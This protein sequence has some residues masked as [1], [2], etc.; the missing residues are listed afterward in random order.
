MEERPMSAGKQRLRPVAKSLPQGIR[1]FL[2][3]SLFKQVRSVRSR[4]KLPRWDI[5][6]L[7][8]VLI[9]CSWCC[10][11]SLPERFEVARGFYVFT[12]PK[13]RRPGTTFS[14]FE[15]AVAKLPMSVLRR[16]AATVRERMVRV[17]GEQWLHEGFVPL[18][19]DGSR[20]E[21]PRSEEL[22]RRLGTFGKDGAA[23]MLW[24]TSIVHLRLGIPWCWWWGRGGKASERSHLQ[25]MIPWLPF[26]ALLIADA[27][28]VGY[29]LM[30]SLIIA[31]VCFL[32]RMSSHATFYT[33]EEQ[34]LD[35]FCEGIV[36]YWP[37]K[38]RAKGEP[39]L[40]GRLI[41]VRDK[42]RKVDVW[43]FTNV[44]D[45]QRL[46]VEAAGKF[47]SW[48]W[49]CEGFFRSYK[50][51][52]KMMKLSGRTIRTVHREAEASMIAVQLMLCLGSQAVAAKASNKGTA[53]VASPRKV[54]LA[55]RSAMRGKDAGSKYSKQIALATRDSRQR[56]THKEQRKWP[57][58]KTHQPPSPPVLLKLPDDLKAKIRPDLLAA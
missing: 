14:G 21:C 20:Q 28:Y 25:Q 1:E 15:K 47:Y 16:V 6:P 46:S 9:L 17:F 18:G 31:N 39:P 53:A 29:Q 10:G 41:C 2:T 43:L 44:E 40:R 34:Q 52:M 4:R 36:Y 23:P 38:I 22:E 56:V 45:R 11:D 24:N 50:R 48:R 27:G 8:Y 33:L 42:R 58:R 57:R 19:C 3:P 55:I 30:R 54:L 13:K 26:N 49:E 7:L 5:H 32:I 35:Q 37:Q 51:T 12:C